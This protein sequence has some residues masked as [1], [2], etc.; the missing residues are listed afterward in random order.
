M[1]LGPQ[2]LAGLIRGLK[3]L[4]FP[5][6]IFYELGKRVNALII[7]QIAE[8]KGYKLCVSRKINTDLLNLDHFVVS[9]FFI[10]IQKDKIPYELVK[11]TLGQRVF[12][13]RL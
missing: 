9:L 5:F 4:L 2:P 6:I 12:C 13:R 3:F 11:D 7:D 10:N 8:G 1:V